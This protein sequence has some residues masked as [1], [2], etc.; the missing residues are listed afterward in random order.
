MPSLGNRLLKTGG[1]LN[2]GVALLHIGIAFAGA[3]AY[4][5][6]GAGEQMAS[7]AEAGSPLPAIIT[8]FLA[9]VFSVF[10]LYAFSG[11]GLIRKLPL[12]ITGLVL[13][14]AIYTLRGLVVIPA[15]I[16]L[17]QSPEAIEPQSIVFSLAALGDRA[18]LPDR[19][20]LQTCISG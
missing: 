15:V 8:L 4:R 12:L 18:A 3:P 9:A 7:W 5:Y 17:I 13:I 10:G 11:A 19:R 2:I 6:F 1:S 20:S 16:V 14:G